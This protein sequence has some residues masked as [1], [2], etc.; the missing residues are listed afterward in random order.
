VVWGQIKRWIVTS[1]PSWCLN[2]FFRG[3]AQ[4]RG[5]AVDLAVSFYFLAGEL[6]VKKL[7]RGE[8]FDLDR[9]CVFILRHFVTLQMIRGE[10]SDLSKRALRRRQRQTESKQ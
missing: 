2:T 1:N 7:R 3:R 9:S 5:F 10:Q 4:E 6:R 8:L